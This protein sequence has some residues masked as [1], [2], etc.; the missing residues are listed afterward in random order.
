DT[1]GLGFQYGWRGVY[2]LNS[3]W[4]LGVEMFG[5][6][7]DLANAGSFNSQNH[8]LGPTLFYTRGGSD[9]GSA[10][11]VRPG[12]NG[13]DVEQSSG[14]PEAELSLNIGLQFGLTD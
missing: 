11:G 5:E 8:S 10:E 9:E 13:A 7:E 14:S 12:S 1:Q 3:H 6:I 2:A 4:G